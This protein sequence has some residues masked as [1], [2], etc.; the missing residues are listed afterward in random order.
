MWLWVAIDADT[1]LVRC[2]MLGPR[3]A[4]DASASVTDLASRLRNRVEMT[5]DGHRPYLEAVP[6]S[7]TR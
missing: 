1:K 7:T 4:A 3:N 5:S 2:V 6:T